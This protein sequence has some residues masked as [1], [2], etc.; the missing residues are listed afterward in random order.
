[1]N[2]SKFFL[3]RNV[4]VYSYQSLFRTFP[5]LWE[6]QLTLGFLPLCVQGDCR[7]V[8]LYSLVLRGFYPLNALIP[9]I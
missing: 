4:F 5:P 9:L 8:S 7:R 1:M 2:W 6:A 3:Y